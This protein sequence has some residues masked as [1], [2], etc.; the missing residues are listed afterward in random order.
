MEELFLNEDKDK[1]EVGK[2]IMQ[3]KV[4]NYINRVTEKLHKKKGIIPGSF[5]G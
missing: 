3:H 2:I 1:G 4:K 5:R